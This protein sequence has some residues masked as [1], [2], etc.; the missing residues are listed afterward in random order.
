MLSVGL[1]SGSAPWII[2]PRRPRLYSAM[3]SVAVLSRFSVS[4]CSLL[5]GMVASVDHGFGDRRAEI[6]AQEV[7]V[8]AFV[9]LLDVLDEHP[10]IATLVAHRRRGPLGP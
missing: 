8:A 6:G 1:C 5:R 7:E 9:C 2:W 4:R 10:G 3:A